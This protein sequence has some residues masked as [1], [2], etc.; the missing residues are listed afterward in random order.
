MKKPL[1]YDL[2]AEVWNMDS[3]TCSN[4]VKYSLMVMK[5]NDSGKR[6]LVLVSLL[7]IYTCLQN[8]INVCNVK[9]VILCLFQGVCMHLLMVEGQ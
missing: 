6:W 7:I 2:V 3:I 9:I 5:F 1:H 8:N 4:K